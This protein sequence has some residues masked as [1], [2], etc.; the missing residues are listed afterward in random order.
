M[1]D[2]DHN[3]VVNW[4]DLGRYDT[5]VAGGGGNLMVDDDRFSAHDVPVP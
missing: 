4:N 3:G 5:I 1:M 2:Y